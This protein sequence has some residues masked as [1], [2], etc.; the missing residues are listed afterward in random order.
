[1]PYVMKPESTYQPVFF[2]LYHIFSIALLASMVFSLRAVSSISIALLILT[3]IAD[4]K[5]NKGYYLPKTLL[6]PLLAGCI[7]FY[8]L[9]L[10]ALPQTGNTAEAWRHIILKSGLLFIP[11]AVGA[12]DFFN[13]KNRNQLL[14]V[15]M[16]LLLIGSL[17]CLLTASQ[18][19]ALYRDADSFFYHELVSPLQ[20]H[21]VFY[22]IFVFVA[23]L[24]LLEGFRKK[25][26][27]F[28]P[29]LHIFL[30]L[31]FSVFLFLLSSRLVLAVYFIYLLYFFLHLIKSKWLVSAL[32]FLI[33]AATLL[34][35]V[36]PNPVGSR[37]RDL[38]RENTRVLK[39]E[40]F[41]PGI[42]FNGFEFRLLQWRLVPEIL[43]E[44]K[45]WLTGVTPGDALDLLNEKYVEKNMYTGNPARGD[46]GYL[47]F[48]THNQFL[49][50]LLQS[51]LP[52]LFAFVIIC[53][54]LIRM[55]LMN[56]NRMKSFVILL[57]LLYALTESVFET[58]YGLLL[59]LFFPLFLHQPSGFH[60]LHRQPASFFPD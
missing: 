6:T 50:S 39:Q 45:A 20:H 16:V 2:L 57:L 38:L 10:I 49:E 22:S 13:E 37:F 9:L 15:Y 4:N 14:H 30:V 18:R 21:A 24:F 56:K 8:S 29:A 34:M 19:F 7:L 48:N 25:N 35:L 44:K 28:G 26:I 33:A 43:S 60:P 55:A 32:L 46:R 53:F 59:F 54:S 52:G 47:G 1:M 11:A 5:L 3:A 23:L 27:Q 36:I 31:Y 41:D 58:Q 12:S 17:Y 51:G 42:Y 40:S